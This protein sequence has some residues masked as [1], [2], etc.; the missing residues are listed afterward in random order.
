MASAQKQL[1]KS[2]A[3]HPS[4]PSSPA[5]R[6]IP[7]SHAPSSSQPHL[8]RGETIIKTS[9]SRRTP[10]LAT[11]PP[12]ARE[13]YSPT[14]GPRNSAYSNSQVLPVLTSDP[15]P[16]PHR[17]QNGRVT[18]MGSSPTLTS[19]AWMSERPQMTPAPRPHN[20][21]LP[22]PNTVKPPTSHML[23]SSPAPFWKYTDQ[24]S[25]PAGWG[26]S[27]FLGVGLQSSS[28]PP[29][30]MNENESPT[31][32]RGVPPSGAG[33]MDA[34]DDDD[35]GGIDLA[36]YRHPIPH[37]QNAQ[38]NCK[39]Q[40]PLT[41]SCLQ[42]VSSHKLLSPSPKPWCV[43]QCSCIRKDSSSLLLNPYL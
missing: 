25:T 16:L 20:L 37:L 26:G 13:S 14:R 40:R 28:P 39:T 35:D 38:Q 19:G 22:L 10:P 17:L 9:P 3:R 7:A 29:A 12:A 31:R 33:R 21:E 43:K 41:K 27:P 23:D 5:G 34:E 6:D 8:T 36:R 32:K 11:Y 24:P 4:N 42:G 30:G 2:G 1:I 15:S 18:V